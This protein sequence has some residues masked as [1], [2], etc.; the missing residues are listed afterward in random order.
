[1]PSHLACPS[2]SWD[3][4]G[5]PAHAAIR[6]SPEAA[7]DVRSIQVSRAIQLPEQDAQLV[8]NGRAI[9]TLL[10][11]SDAGD[12]TGH[13]VGRECTVGPEP[14]TRVFSHD[15]AVGLTR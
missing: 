11:Q 14:A 8:S 10:T 13:H 12:L 9:G 2:V 7:W 15:P 5:T 6:P 4:D 1:M 3:I